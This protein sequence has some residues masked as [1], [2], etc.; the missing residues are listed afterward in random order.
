MLGGRGDTDRWDTESPRWLTGPLQ[1]D[2]IASFLGYRCDVARCPPRERRFSRGLFPRWPASPAQSRDL[3]DP[4]RRGDAERLRI[5]ARNRRSIR[6]YRL[7]WRL[8]EMLV[9]LP[10]WCPTAETRN[11][12]WRRSRLIKR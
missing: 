3:P 1:D 11:R 9:L 2:P 5:L 4:T 7:R 6:V 10:L 12:T 8:G